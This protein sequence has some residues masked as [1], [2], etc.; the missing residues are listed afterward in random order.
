MHKKSLANK[1][2]MNSFFVAQLANCMETHSFHRK[3]R[4]TRERIEN[5]IALLAVNTSLIREKH[6][7]C[8]PS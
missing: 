2:I 8:H 7:A 5:E 6:T 3:K 4:V 1:K